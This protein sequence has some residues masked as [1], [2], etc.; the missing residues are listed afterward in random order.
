MYKDLGFPLKPRIDDIFHSQGI[1]AEQSG[2]IR[3]GPG[4]HYPVWAE[5][6]V[7]RR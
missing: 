5:L 1:S 2:I 7:R 6:V 3:S 4:D